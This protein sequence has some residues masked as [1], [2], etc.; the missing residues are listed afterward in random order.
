MN[1]LVK[2][3]YASIFACSYFDLMILN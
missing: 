2:D 3:C 1:L